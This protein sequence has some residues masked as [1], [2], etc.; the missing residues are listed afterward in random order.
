MFVCVCERER[1]W[2]GG[3]GGGDCWDF[4][5]D[6]VCVSVCVT[7]HEECSWVCQF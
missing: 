6:V 7:V 4:V 1:V 2:G 3:G 5:V